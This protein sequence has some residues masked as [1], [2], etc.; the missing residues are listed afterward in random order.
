[1][2]ALVTGGAGFI[3]SHICE[4]LLKE[5]H[6]VV[7]LDNFDPYYAPSLK[8]ENIKPLFG[9]EKFNLIEGDIRD[10]ELVQQAMKQGIDYV[11]HNAAQPG[12][13]A[14]IENPL[15]S[16]EVNTTGL[17]NILQACLNS[18]VKKI[19][20]A[21]SSSVYGKVQYL[22]LDED[23]PTM[24]VSPYGVSKLTAE[25]YCRVFSKIYGLKITSLRLFT[26]YGPRMRPDLAISIFTKRALKNQTIEIFGSGDKTRDFTYIDDVVK[27]NL[28]A[29]EKGDGEVYNIGSG[30]RI[31]IKGLANRIIQVL[32]SNSDI[33]YMPPL[34]GEAE[35]TWANVEKAREEFG[36]NP[37]VDLNQG[38]QRYI[39]W[40]RSLL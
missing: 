35:H 18:K 22:L 31:S 11:F 39:E 32:G 1:M 2:R 27:A 19:I 33:V 14:S 36:Y 21:S 34:K 7:C 38:L 37:Q 3:G 24:P 5:G 29:M 26:V 30:A 8:R 4:R 20:N 23:H 16:H 15:K 25:Y 13:R 28:L 17:L 12:V 40:W 10:R 9:S 6:Y